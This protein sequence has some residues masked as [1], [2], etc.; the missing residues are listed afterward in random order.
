MWLKSFWYK[1]APGGEN[2]Q[3]SSC[4][5]NYMTDCLLL[6]PI[7]S[8][9]CLRCLQLEAKITGLPSAI[10]F[11]SLFHHISYLI[12]N[13]IVEQ[14]IKFPGIVQCFCLKFIFNVIKRMQDSGKQKHW[15]NAAKTLVRLGLRLAWLPYIQNLPYFWKWMFFLAWSPSGLAFYL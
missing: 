10:G 6:F 9:D 3:Y 12:A 1:G 14:T 4:L 8:L 11:L 13:W 7:T 15:L 5:Q 2:W